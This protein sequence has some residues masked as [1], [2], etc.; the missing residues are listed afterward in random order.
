LS[1]QDQNNLEWQAGI[2]VS[3]VRISFAFDGAKPDGR[4]AARGVLERALTIVE[5]LQKVDGFARRKRKG[6]VEDL[7]KR[8][9]ELSEPEEKESSHG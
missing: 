5:G 7:K 3:L 9:A 2:V 1:R 4:K 8:L 6:W